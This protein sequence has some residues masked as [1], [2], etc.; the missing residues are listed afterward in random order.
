MQR[1]LH[2]KRLSNR[3]EVGGMSKPGVLPFRLNRG[4]TNDK[5]A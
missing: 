1:A 2:S 5:L 4:K 3:A